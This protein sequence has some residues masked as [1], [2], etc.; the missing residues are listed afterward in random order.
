MRPRSR[1]RSYSS[2]H[3]SCICAASRAADRQALK[4][5]LRAAVHDN[6]DPKCPCPRGG[7]I[8]AHAELHPNDLR[9]WI[10][11][12]RLIDNL[13][14][15]S[16]VA[17]NIHHV[18]RLGNIRQTFEKRRAVKAL[19]GKA[20]IDPQHMVPLREQKDENAVGRPCFLIRGT[21]HRDGF[22]LQKNVAQKTV[23]A[24]KIPS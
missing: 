23:G 22:D 18:D 15:G 1:T 13:S 8:V 2:R 6:F 11:S 12:Q 4:F 17:E 24:H 7:R 16:R 21:D 10:E 19:A 14:S 5:D 20:G 9:F 3:A